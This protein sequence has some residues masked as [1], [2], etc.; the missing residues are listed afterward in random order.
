L[1]PSLVGSTQLPP[2]SI[3]AADG[4]PDT[5][6]YVP[7]APAHTLDAPVH[8]VPQLP[9]LS[10]VE[11]WTQAPAQRLY[12]S[13]HPNEQPVSVQVGWALATVV[14]HALPHIPQLEGLVRSTHPALHS[15]SPVGQPPAS[16][17][18]PELLP[19][20]PTSVAP[21]LSSAVLLSASTPPPLLLLLLAEA[22]SPITPPASSVTR[23]EL[24]CAHA[25]IDDA[26]A[27]RK[28]PPDATNRRPLILPSLHIAL[29][30]ITPYLARVR[31][32]A[33][34][35]VQRYHPDDAE[36][37]KNVVTN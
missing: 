14:E 3:G 22:S 18:P 1:F 28:R 20:G 11:S 16:T 5:Q 21:P 37:G 34:N 23:P 2:Q 26:R 36:A 7:S 25:E 12:P 32:G 31:A 24:L 9:Q 13:L 33:H 27:K 4:H 10:A 19:L 29:K 35:S 30:P 15:A 17:S 8:A 6:E